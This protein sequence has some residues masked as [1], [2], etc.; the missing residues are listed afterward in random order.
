MTDIKVALIGA[1]GIGNAHS[2]AYEHISNAEITA[3]V[4]VRREYAEKLATIHHAKAYTSI[5]EMFAHENIH[6]VD[7]CTPAFTHP[8]IAIQCAQ[9]GV[10]VLV[11]K[12]IAYTR[13]D[14]HAI[15]EAVQKNG[16]FFMV[17]QVIRFWNEYVYLK[18][19]YDTGVHGKLLQVWFS[20]VCG[21]PLWA[22]ENWYVDPARSG[23][24][25]FELHI[26]DV[27]YIHYLLGKPDR[28]HSLAI[29]RPEIYASFIKSQFFYD[30]LPGVIV[31]AE[32]GWW[33]GHVPF[34]ATFRAVFEN[35]MLVYDSDKMTVYEAK[36]NSPRIVDLSTEVKLASS[37]N[38]KDTSGIYNEIAYFLECIKTNTAPAIITPEQS[39]VSLHILLTELESARTGAVLKV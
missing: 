13:E 36:A 6:M 17:A 16:V 2:N 10:H 31:E 30:S 21:V 23:Y 35:A 28:V 4:D 12:P 19:I 1:G 25:P 20:R 24:A 26:H 33:Q 18:H 34:A 8:E 32:A 3:V 11:E 7:I 15:L 5:E 29:H 37:I 22:W 14:A 9:H 38:L 27:D 39:F